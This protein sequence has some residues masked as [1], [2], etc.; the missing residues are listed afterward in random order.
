VCVG[1]A[2][3]RAHWVDV[4]GSYQRFALQASALGIGTRRPDLVVRIGRGPKLPVSLRRPVD[5]VI[6]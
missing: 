6:V 4:G 1:R 2:A 3:D 5:A